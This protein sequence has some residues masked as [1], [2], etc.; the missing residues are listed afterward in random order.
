MKIRLE[1]LSATTSLLPLLQGEF[2][3]TPIRVE[4]PAFKLAITGDGEEDPD[5]PL[6]DEIREVVDPVVSLITSTLPDLWRHYREI[7]HPNPCEC[8]GFQRVLINPLRDGLPWASCNWHKPR[9][10]LPP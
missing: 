8:S 6:L 7:P 2:E 3:L 5:R 4:A 10:R 9:E 1:D